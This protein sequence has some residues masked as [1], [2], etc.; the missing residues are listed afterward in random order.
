MGYI[1]KCLKKTITLTLLLLLL[2]LPLLLLL[3]LQ[4]KLN[5]ST[6]Y[7]SSCGEYKLANIRDLTTGYD[8]EQVD[9]K[10]V[11]YHHSCVSSYTPPHRNLVT[12]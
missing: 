1:S 8:S 2:L 6:K 11:S 4:Q 12:V 10:A 7:P 9:N 3:L 5:E